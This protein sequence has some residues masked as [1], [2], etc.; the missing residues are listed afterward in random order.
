MWWDC[1]KAAS[2][3]EGPDGNWRKVVCVSLERKGACADPHWR[4]REWRCLLPLASFPS[5]RG[6]RGWPVVSGAGLHVSL[7]PFLPP[8]PTVPSPGTPCASSGAEPGPVAG[9][10]RSAFPVSWSLSSPEAPSG[11]LLAARPL[12]LLLE[13]AWAA[14]AVSDAESVSAD[15]DLTERVSSLQP[16]SPPRLCL[17][18]AGGLALSALS[19]VLSPPCRLVLWEAP[20]ALS[21]SCLL[22]PC[23]HGPRRVHAFRCWRDLSTCRPALTSP[24]HFLQPLSAETF[25]TYRVF[26]LVTSRHRRLPPHPPRPQASPQSHWCQAVVTASAPCALSGPFALPVLCSRLAR[27]RPQSSPLCASS[28]RMAVHRLLWPPDLSLLSDQSLDDCSRLLFSQTSFAV[29]LSWYFSSCFAKKAEALVSERSPLAWVCL[30]VL[31]LA[32]PPLGRGC[33]WPSPVQRAASLLPAAEL[34][35]LPPLSQKQLA[36]FRRCGEAPWFFST[37]WENK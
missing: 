17:L 16:P 15:P 10:Q 25:H 21:W 35:W 32:A 24:T 6:A 20:G 18:P 13:P 36:P 26:T 23:E 27:L 9:P 19:Q 1:V 11:V 8:V 14:L 12:A 7:R 33:G 30:R 5:G 22:P 34:G 29:T 2:R 4:G 31:C 37:E 3:A 28:S